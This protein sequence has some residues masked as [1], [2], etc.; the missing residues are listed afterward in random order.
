MMS[1]Y[2]R[3]LRALRGRGI[4]LY[5]EAD[6]I[7]ITRTKYYNINSGHTKKISHADLELIAEYFQVPLR[8]MV[9]V[10]GMVK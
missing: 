3:A 2:L 9:I 4:T 6:L 5:L 7:G 8:N 1:D 10:A